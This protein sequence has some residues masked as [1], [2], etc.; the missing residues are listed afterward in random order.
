MLFNSPFFLTIHQ[1]KD[2]LWHS[3]MRITHE[4]DAGEGTLWATGSMDYSNRED[5]ER[6]ARL[7]ARHEGYRYVESAEEIQ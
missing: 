4:L 1:T 2:G 5:A 3:A 7:W 6:E